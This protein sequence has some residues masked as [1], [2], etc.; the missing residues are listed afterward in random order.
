[1]IG[2]SSAL[3]SNIQSELNFRFPPE[4]RGNDGG[5][6]FGQAPSYSDQ[7]SVTLPKTSDQFLRI[8]TNCYL[9]ATRSG[10]LVERYLSYVGGQLEGLKLQG[11][12][13]ER[14]RVWL[15]SEMVMLW[16]PAQAPGARNW[17]ASDC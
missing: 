9:R 2:A 8:T 1:M 12:P 6:V 7:G 3:I 5:P 15:F 16:S 17:V 13:V 11:N 14:V 4:T 10:Y